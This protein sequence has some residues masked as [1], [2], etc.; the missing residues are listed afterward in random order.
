MLSIAAV[1]GLQGEVR[2]GAPNLRMLLARIASSVSGIMHVPIEMAG[3]CMTIGDTLVTEEEAVPIAMVLNE[4]MMN[5]IKHRALIG[6]DATVRIDAVCNV[7]GVQIEISNAGVLPARFNLPL[8]VHVGT[9]LG[10]VKSLLPQRGAVL[11][12]VE[13]GRRVV[14]RL[15]LLTPEVLMTPAPVTAE[16]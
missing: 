13:E 16:N 15:T 6:E 7:G 8:G 10:L 3:Q 14:A 2:R 1:H 4:L 5:A 9:G 11:E 12:I